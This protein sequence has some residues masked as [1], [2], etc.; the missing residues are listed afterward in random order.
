ML[1]LGQMD[2]GKTSLCRT[3]LNYAQ[4]QNHVPIYVN[5]DPN[6]DTAC[7]P[8]CISATSV[9]DLIL[10][11]SDLLTDLVSSD[12]VLTIPYALYFGSPHPKNNPDLFKEL[13]SRLADKVNSHIIA[14]PKESDGGIFI[15]TPGNLDNVAHGFD[16][17]MHIIASFSSTLV[18]FLSY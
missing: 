15:D 1:I 10:P 9:A 12:E 6:E 7:I 4:R 17:I 14:H 5:L 11:E 8:G 3:L 18:S 2:S 16:L 13:C